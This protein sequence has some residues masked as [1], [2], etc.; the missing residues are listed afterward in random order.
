MAYRIKE[1]R[2]KNKMSQQKLAEASGISR[3]TIAALENNVQS[4]AM[5]GTLKA[6]AVAL[7]VPISDLLSE[8]TDK[9]N[10]NLRE[11]NDSLRTQID[12]I[13]KNKEMT[14]GALKQMAK[15][16]GVSPGDLLT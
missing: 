10:K 14:V 15:T 4:D 2:E 12:S 6:L 3:A 16:L 13:Q 1:L 9:V 5:V 8:T 11:E 7:K